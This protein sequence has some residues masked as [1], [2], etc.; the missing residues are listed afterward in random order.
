MNKCIAKDCKR[1]QINEYEQLCI[2]HTTQVIK[3]KY[4]QELKYHKSNKDLPHIKLYVVGI[5]KGKGSWDRGIWRKFSIYY[6][7][8]YGNHHELTRIWLGYADCPHWVKP[9]PE[10]KGGYFEDRVLGM[11]RVFDIV[12]NLGIWLFNDGYYF[13]SEF[14]SGV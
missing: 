5:D 3:E 14:L 6:M 9:K 2:K 12:Y 4:Q 8:R 1:N 13:D 11:D 7:K 10:F